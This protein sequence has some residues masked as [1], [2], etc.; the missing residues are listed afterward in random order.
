MRK[1]YGW[2][3]AAGGLLVACGGD[4]DWPGDTSGT[5]STSVGGSAGAPSTD[6]SAGTNGGS[7]SGTQTGAGGSSGGAGGTG[8]SGGGTEGS[9]DSG[10]MS[11]AAGMAGGAGAGGTGGND[12]G[13]PVP[14]TE[15][16]N[17][18]P[19][20]GEVPPLQL[21][22]VAGG[23]LQPLLVTFAPGDP[24]RLF[25]VEQPGTIRIIEDGEVVEE[26]FLDL[27]ASVRN[28]NN[29]QGLLGLAFHPDYAENG[30]FYVYYT[31]RA[32]VDGAGGVERGDIVVSEFSVSAAPNVAEID[33]ER[34]LLTQT[35]PERNHNGGMLAFGPDGFLYI[36]LG[37][38]G[39]S[40]DPDE[41]G[42]NTQTWLGKLLRI[43]VDASDAGEYGIPDGNMESPALPEIYHYGLR[44]P[45][46]YSFDGCQG[47]LYL[48]DVGQND[49]EELNVVP[50]GAAHLNFGWNVCEG[51][52]VRGGTAACE[53][54]E[55][56]APIADYGRG[57][58][59]CITGG[60]VYRGSLIPALRGTY[61]YADYAS[62]AF[63]AFEYVGGEMTNVREL[64]EELDTSSG[65]ISSFGQDYF[66]EVYL[67]R[68]G[69]ADEPTG[70]VQRIEPVP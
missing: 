7:S 8:G 48:G 46:R 41:N 45:W 21:V 22:E 33:S 12:T 6:T 67:T 52:H 30:K 5:S 29:E 23:F 63:F 16:F 13:N 69:A 51:S 35:H 58:G 3:L 47:D 70:V 18:E 68:R 60:Y 54:M 11:G 49:W 59:I 61:F 56:A 17:C 43:D 31:A 62:G 20:E 65:A 15:G 55:F 38:G 50:H 57:V 40:N 24:T 9:S 1:T 28:I 36:G 42:Q 44:N 26:P 4:D 34:M 10:G 25:V 53:N 37:D 32:S 19:S 64:T 27:T 14:G 2:M 39:G 66:G